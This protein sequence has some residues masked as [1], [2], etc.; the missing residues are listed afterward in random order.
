MGCE[1]RPDSTAGSHGNRLGY[2]E[3]KN[4]VSTF[5]RLFFIHS[6][7]YLQVTITCMRA[8]TSSNFGL[9]GPPTAELAALERLKKIPKGL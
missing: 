5:S 6:L 8:R 2:D 9:I 4:G 3:K 1:I 7:S